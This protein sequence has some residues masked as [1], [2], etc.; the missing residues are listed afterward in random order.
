MANSAATHTPHQHKNPPALLQSRN[1]TSKMGRSHNDEGVGSEE[2][3]TS[4]VAC[5]PPPYALTSHLFL[6]GYIRITMLK[7]PMA[8]EYSLRP[9]NRLLNVKMP[10]TIPWHAEMAVQVRHMPT[11]MEEGLFWS[12]LNINHEDSHCSTD[13]HR[14]SLYPKSFG[15]THARIFRL[16]DKAHDIPQWQASIVIYAHGYP[17]LQRFKPQELT[18]DN[19][20]FTVAK[21]GNNDHV[22]QFDRQCSSSNFNAIFGDKPLSGWWPW[23]KEESCE[24]GMSITEDNVSRY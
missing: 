3:T 22:Y 12:Q 6:G 24:L 7:D 14:F 5:S 16:I 17:E 13:T 19:I 9:I 8:K 2:H 1:R 23:P 18:L 11:L 4:I 15:Y 10:H 21:N 20:I